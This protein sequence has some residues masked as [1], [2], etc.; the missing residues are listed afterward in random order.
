MK[1]GV[2]VISTNEGDLL[3]QALPT[4]L[5]Q[6]GADFDVVVLDNASEDSTADVATE[7]GVRHVWLERRHS[8]CEAMNA[9]LRAV[10]GEVLLFMQPD[11]FLT[12]GFVATGLRRL[13]EPDVGS[14]APKLIRTAGP[15]PQQRPHAPHTPGPGVDRGGQKG[16]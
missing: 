5:E 3:R 15:R 12:P 11:T 6:D 14:V 7:L 16:R 9:G 4:M 10:E 2:P 8:F 13:A 1:V